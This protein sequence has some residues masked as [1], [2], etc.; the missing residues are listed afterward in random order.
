MEILEER[1]H[2]KRP[3]PELCWISRHLF[4]IHTHTCTHHALHLLHFHKGPLGQHDVQ[5]SHSHSPR[6]PSFDIP[7]SP[8]PV[9]PAYLLSG[10]SDLYDPAHPTTYPAL[11][12]LIPTLPAHPAR[13]PA[14][15]AIM[16][17]PC[18]VSRYRFCRDKDVSL[19]LL[20]FFDVLIPYSPIAGLSILAFGHVLTLLTF[21]VLGFD[22][23]PSHP[24][25]S[26]PLLLNC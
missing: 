24:G 23:A 1:S 11:P 7:S 9:L 26:S 19:C 15:P 8:K 20:C 25:Q 6:S 14:H 16:F 18:Y 22:R 4:H 3:D 13:Y 5:S 17:W 21:I 10:S 12:A 2:L